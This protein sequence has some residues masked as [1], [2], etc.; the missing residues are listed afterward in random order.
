MTS[1]TRVN[2]WTVT[3]WGTGT[4]WTVRCTSQGRGRTETTTWQQR[5]EGQTRWRT[6]TQVVR[7]W[8]E[9]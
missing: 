9:R 7:G 5:R 4:R 2:E 1:E 6:V 3:Q 8:T